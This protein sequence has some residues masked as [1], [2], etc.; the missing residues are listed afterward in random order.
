MINK[1]KQISL[2]NWVPEIN[3]EK[4]DKNIR[5]ITY[6]ILCDSLLSCSTEINEEEL[7][8]FPNLKWEERKKKILDELR[9]LDADIICLQEFERDEEMIKYLGEMGYD[10]I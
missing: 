9:E 10:V 1:S 5:I 8:N 3:I 2:R 4:S 6:N 7:A